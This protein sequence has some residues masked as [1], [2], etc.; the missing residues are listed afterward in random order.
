M[1]RAAI[2]VEP[3]EARTQLRRFAEVPYALHHDDPR[4]RPPLRAFDQWRLDARRHPYF[5]RGD[6]AYFLAR[7]AGQPVGRIAAHVA[8]SEAAD[9]AFGFFDVPDDV[10]VAVALLDAA[11]TWLSEQGANSMTG[12]ISWSSEEEFGVLVDGHDLPA[13]TG[14]PWHP[15]SYAELLAAAGLAPGEKRATHRLATDRGAEEPPPGCD[16]SPPEH[17]GRYADRHL[18]LDGIA[19]VPDVSGLIAGAS[20]RSAWQVARQARTRSFDTAVCVRCE[21]DP[22][23]LV[24]LLSRA[25]A[26]AG[27]PWLLAPWSPGDDPPE[28]VHQV[29]STEW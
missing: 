8:S 21:G 26:H 12:P 22:A 13:T 9:G 28:R 2:T 4:W 17:A 23:A 1:G 14:R 10:E 25:A 24:P 27:Y 20:L 7:R 6:A 5:D 16:T 18:V 29:F 19:A 11:R 3:V 15:A